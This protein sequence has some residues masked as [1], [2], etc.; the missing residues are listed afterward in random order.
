M[1][2]RGR[3]SEKLVRKPDN[4]G[5][6]HKEVRIA[7]KSP[8][9]PIKM[10]ISLFQIKIID[11]VCAGLDFCILNTGKNKPT[12]DDL[13]NMILKH[14]GRVV[15]NPSS[16]T[17]VCIAD[18]KPLNVKMLI[19]SAKYNIA[20]VDWLVNAFGGNAPLK[21]L[22]KL[23]PLEMIYSTMELQQKFSNDYDSYGDSYTQPVTEN[24][25]K[26]F[27][28]KM[29]T[30]DV[31]TFTASELYDMEKKLSSTLEPANFFRLCTAYF[32][33][34]NDASNDF[35]LSKFIFKSKSGRCLNSANE[36]NE[37]HSKLTHIFIDK[38]QFQWKHLI[39][40]Q[41][42]PDIELNDIKIVSYQWIL[43]CYR[44]NMLLCDTNYHVIQK[45]I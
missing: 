37:S 14:G 42:V 5:V 17:F 23:H 13:K 15:A 40:L 39:A 18:Y 24:S 16:K 9:F 8:Q 25:I 19:K 26:N 34:T 29:N 38:D 22:P 1:P 4:L 43:D 33:Q 30:T 21:R 28:E 41:L 7:A 35:E 32:N 31:P 20:T 2:K 44:S 12:I 10:V 6:L 3:K 36:I 11:K 45:I 27:L